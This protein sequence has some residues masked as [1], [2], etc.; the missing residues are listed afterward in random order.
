LVDLAPGRVHQGPPGPP[1]P[2]HSRFGVCSPGPALLLAGRHDP[3]LLAEYAALE[4]RIGHR[5]RRELPPADVQ[6]ALAA[7]EEPGPIQDWLM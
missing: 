5:F 6:A 2:A 4:R 3:E 1:T 7:G